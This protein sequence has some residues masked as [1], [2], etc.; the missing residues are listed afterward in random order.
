MQI[1]NDGFLLRQYL[2]LSFIFIRL[3]AEERKLIKLIANKGDLAAKLS[4][5]FFDLNVRFVHLDAD[6]D[7]VVFRKKWVLIRWFDV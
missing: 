7:E 3:E 2:I 5:K 6:I 4:Y 1:S